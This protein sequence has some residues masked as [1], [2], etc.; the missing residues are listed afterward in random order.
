MS[1]T[2]L[3]SATNILNKKSSVQKALNE[4]S[5]KSK[6]SFAFFDKKGNKFVS[7]SMDIMIN[8]ANL[9]DKYGIKYTHHA[10]KINAVPEL[11]INPKYIEVAQELFDGWQ[12]NITVEQNTMISNFNAH[13]R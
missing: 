3:I 10:K 1:K 6:A 7:D 13:D 11:V 8:I 12:S 5:K 4:I 9:L 2:D